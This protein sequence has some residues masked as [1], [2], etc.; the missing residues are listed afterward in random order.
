MLKRVEGAEAAVA[1]L[2]FSD[3]RIRVYA[4][5]ARLQLPADQMMKAVE[6]RSDIRK[7]VEKYF[8]VVMMDLKDR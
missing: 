3:F 6:M 8:S 1:S 5:A 4:D 7:A 2:G